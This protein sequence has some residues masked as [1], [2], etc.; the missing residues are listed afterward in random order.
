MPPKRGANLSIEHQITLCHCAV[1]VLEDA[2]I[3]INQSKAEFDKRVA[4]MFNAKMKEVNGPP[5][6]QN[7]L[8]TKWAAIQKVCSAYKGFYETVKKMGFSGYD[9]EMYYKEANK[10]Y[11]A[12]KSTQFDK[13]GNP[14][15]RPHSDD[16]EVPYSHCWKSFLR[17]HTKWSIDEV[18]GEKV[19]AG[20]VALSNSDTES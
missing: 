4:D 19:S 5:R 7:F 13:N 18:H 14:L 15:P 10:L 16:K 8:R 20:P 2:V 17:N 3:G 1:T 9:E 6:S 11:N 12:K